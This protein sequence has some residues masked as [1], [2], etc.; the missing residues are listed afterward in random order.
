[1]THIRPITEEHFDESVALMQFAF[2]RQMPAERLDQLRADYR[3]E[4]EYGLFADDGRLLS[5]LSVL[6]LEVWIRG[7]KL[8]MGGVA[9]VASWPDARRQG[10]VRRLLQHAFERMRENGQ[11]ISMLAPF[12]FAFYRKFG[13]ESTIERKLYT[14]ETKHLTMRADTPGSV[15]IAAKDWAALDSVYSGYASQF[16]GAL[17][18]DA[19]WW[20]QRILSKPGLAAVYYD[21]DGRPQGYMLYEVSDRTLKVQDWAAVTEDARIALWTYAGNHDSMITQLTMEA[22]AD[23]P[24]SFLVEDPR[25]KQEIQPY[26]MSRIIDAENFIAQYRFAGADRTSEVALTIM[27]AHAPWNE[28]SFALRIEADGSA[29]LARGAG[30]GGLSCDIQTLTA[31]LVGHRRPAWLHRIGRLQGPV[32]QALELDRRVPGQRPFLAD[33]F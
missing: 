26:F 16:D 5:R 17:A 6:P 18:R 1:M 28:G 30:G 12:S 23:D 29:R 13:Y 10:G 8:A 15:R 11:S 24:L 2:Q 32:E 31:M 22:P 27:D 4:Q 25:F 7:S 21:E 33:Y 3:P 20:E 14:L 19:R 9:S